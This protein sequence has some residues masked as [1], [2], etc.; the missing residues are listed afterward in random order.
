M[1]EEIGT[2]ININTD[3]IC[4]KCLFYESDYMPTEEG[5]VH[6][7][8]CHY[9]EGYCSYEK[10]QIMSFQIHDCEN[11]TPNQ[12]YY[13]KDLEKKYNITILYAVE[14]GSRAWHFHNEKSDYDIRFIYK[15]NNPKEYF[16]LDKYK[17]VIEVTD[18]LYDIVGWDIKKMLFLH[19]KNNPS[20]YEWIKTT[21]EYIP[22]KYMIFK[23]LPDF[24]H[25]SLL[26]HYYSMGKAN[27][28]KY[29]KNVADLE[30]YS[31]EELLK[32]C[33]KYL[34]VIRCILTW[35][36]IHQDIS[37]CLN[38]HQLRGQNLKYANLDKSIDVCIERIIAIYHLNDYGLRL[39]EELEFYFNQLYVWI[40]SELFFMKENVNNTR[41]ME[42][43]SWKVYNERFY[44][45]INE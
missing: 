17:D 6:L 15:Y 18:G 22:D 4:Q 21:Y 20:L 36:M 27:W 38:I 39:K 28:N 2:Y 3:K 30:E 40:E 26:H 45:I 1:K 44:N 7:E 43:K 14:S 10:N 35:T 32:L 25:K 13:L 41:N 11:Y 31:E 24:N 29:C 42:N 8:W 34:Y 19:Y 33:K 12:E 16:R 5:S 37:P 9:K 23:D